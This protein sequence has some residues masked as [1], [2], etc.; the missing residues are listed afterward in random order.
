M[1]C[2][3]MSIKLRRLVRS[4]SSGR[5]GSEGRSLTIRTADRAGSGTETS[6]TANRARSG[7]NRSMN[8]PHNTDVLIVSL[9]STAG[10]READS[11]L[12]ASLKRAGMTVKVVQARPVREW[13]TFALIEFAWALSARRATLE[14]I[15]K[16][17]PVSVIYS[18]T[19]AALLAPRPGVIRF[20]APAAENRPGR[21]G[22]WQRRVERKRFASAPLLLPWS[23]GALRYAP[24]PHAEALV[25]PVPIELPS[26]PAHLAT[27]IDF[28]APSTH[29]PGSFSHASDAIGSTR[30]AAVTYAANP[31]KKGLD[32]TLKAWRA[33]RRGGEILAVAGLNR[34]DEPGV[35][36]TGMLT[37]HE[38]RALLRRARIFVTA[39]RQEDYGVT[40][41]EA[42]AEGCML[43]TTPSPG[44]YVALPIAR[45]LDSR[46]VTNDL[47]NAIRIA[48]DEPANNYTRRATEAL[49]PWRRENTDRIV[50]ER[51]VPRLQTLANSAK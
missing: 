27:P 29:E 8:E 48:L 18:S 1:V 44:P 49:Q 4:A 45:K 20:D 16:Y 38:Y 9:G 46:L 31:A 40:Q 25:V 14:G 35:T 43:V 2:D 21:H 51:L 50:I 37:R 28:S 7:T 23:E 24:T 42:L 13:R 19:T 5:Q 22:I 32:R 6:R 11:E 10:L 17:S 30:T 47:E 15:K 3:F 12:A 41:L 39:P 34:K 36:Y 33:A 26:E